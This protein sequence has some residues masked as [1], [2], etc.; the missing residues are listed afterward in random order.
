MKLPVC[1]FDL[2]SDM[3]CNICQERLNRREISKFDIEFSKWLL[4]RVKEYP[5]IDNL[6]LRRAIQ[7]S[8]RLLLVVKK[9]NAQILTSLESL[10][11]E[12]KESFGEVM[13]FEQ[14]IRLRKI[15]RTLIEPFIEV[16]VNSLYL[17]DGSRESIVMLRDE[18][19]DKITYSKDDLKD[20]VSAIMGESVLFQYQDDRVEKSEVTPKDEFDEKMEEFSSRRGRL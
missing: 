16:G 2:E 14:P 6:D 7:A 17:P 9:K 15:V 13:V 18:D 3:L 10:V 19:R 20:I 5:S 12:M 11:A 1:V 8:G 4:D